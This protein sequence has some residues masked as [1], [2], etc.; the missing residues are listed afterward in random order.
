MQIPMLLLLAALFGCS[1]G[2]SAPEADCPAENRSSVTPTDALTT[3]LSDPTMQGD[4][5]NWTETLER[6]I[7]VI[8]SNATLR[9]A[10][11]NET[12][13]LGFSSA[14]GQVLKGIGYDFPCSPFKLAQPA[15]SVHALTPADVQ[16]VGAIGDSISA[17]SGIHAFTPLGIVLSFRG[18]VFSIGADL[19]YQWIPTL[20]NI[21][22]KY[23]PNLRGYAKGVL[24]KSRGFDVAV[25]GAKS[26]DML[27]QAYDLIQR[28][29]ADPTVDY[30]NDW[31]VI[32]L[33]IGGNDLCAYCKNPRYYAAE[34]YTA[35]IKR[36]LDLL[37]SEVPR[38][39]VNVVNVLDV[40]QI[41][42]LN[43]G[44]ACTVLHY[45]ECRCGAFKQPTEE[46]RQIVLEY[47]GNLSALVNSGVYDTRDDFTVVLQPFLE[48]TVLPKNRCGKPDLAYF[49]PDCFHL[50]GLGNARAAQAL[51]NN[52]IEPVGAKRTDW[53]I[54]E[55][56]E[57]LSPEQPY[58]YTNKNSNK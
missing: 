28:M 54:G 51:W 34:M 38:A 9:Q 57:C 39:F 52:M 33:F 1:A 41:K 32:T 30:Q 35:N 31:K 6:V 2:I 21:L 22:L 47:Q 10:M 44:L 49:A 17:G 43:R 11:L 40:S 26:E 48:K 23:N 36:A 42:E 8:E 29:K 16:V 14:L 25:P 15:T 24:K 56:I 12:A 55:P 37:H 7:K 4:T 20:P 18:S 13:E 53:H 19:N 3:I 45:F 46:L 50:S 58:F 27:K 5:G